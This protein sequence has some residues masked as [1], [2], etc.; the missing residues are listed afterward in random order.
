MDTS[1]AF[2]PFVTLQNLTGPIIA[3]LFWGLK[4]KGPLQ[5]IAPYA[6]RHH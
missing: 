6:S 2:F 4:N 3:N 1:T 5:K